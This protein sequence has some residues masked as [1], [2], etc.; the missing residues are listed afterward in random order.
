MPEAYQLEGNEIVGL[1]DRP[2]DFVAQ[3]LVELG[4][5]HDIREQQYEYVGHDLVRGL[6]TAST[7]WR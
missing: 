1:P 7:G 4:T 6:R 3:S 5:V 2:H